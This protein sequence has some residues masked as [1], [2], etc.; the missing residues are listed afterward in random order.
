MLTNEE[1]NKV[2]KIWEIF[3]TGGIA[4]PL[5]VIE[6]FTYLL[7]IKQLDEAEESR[8][9]VGLS[10]IFGPEQQ[11]YRWGQLKNNGNAEAVFALMRDEV[12]PFIKIGV[13]PLYERRHFQDTDTGCADE[14]Y[15]RHRQT[16]FQ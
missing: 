13:C 5:E 12:F 14:D 2:D 8:E 11:K 1:R 10:G 4:N 9:A 3:W 15:R 16:E 7:F 6:Q